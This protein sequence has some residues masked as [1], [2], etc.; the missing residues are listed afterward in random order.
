MTVLLIFLY[1]KS[2]KLIIKLP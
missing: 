2:A 1:T